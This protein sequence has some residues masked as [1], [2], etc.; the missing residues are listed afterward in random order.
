VASRGGDT[1]FPGEKSSHVATTRSHFLC[2]CNGKKETGEKVLAIVFAA[3]FSVLLLQVPELLSYC[4]LS[5]LRRYHLGGIGALVFGKKRQAT[6]LGGPLL[7]TRKGISLSLSL[8]FFF[9]SLSLS[10]SFV[11]T[12]LRPSDRKGEPQENFC[13][14]SG[15]RG[16][17][18]VLMRAA[19]R[20]IS[21]PASTGRE[22]EREGGGRK[23]LPVTLICGRVNWKEGNVGRT[24]PGGNGGAFSL[25]RP[26]GDSSTATH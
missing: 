10:P 13:L 26:V 17:G 21:P 8:L 25:A 4:Y 23:S 6:I 11:A 9:L 1:F 16:G 7:R 2:P 19:L 3:T 5:Q 15:G 24:L 20:S 12:Q 14:L 18:L 22:E